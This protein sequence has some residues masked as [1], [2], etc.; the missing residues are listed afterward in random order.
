MNCSERQFVKCSGSLE[1]IMIRVA[2][3]QERAS[4]VFK[5]VL[6]TFFPSIALLVYSRYRQAVR[7]D[8]SGTGLYLF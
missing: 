2:G 6:G 4:A 5:A 3:P 1:K 8:L 7:S